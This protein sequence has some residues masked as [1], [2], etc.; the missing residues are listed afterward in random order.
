MLFQN[1]IKFRYFKLIFI[2]IIAAFCINIAY[3]QKT[4][5]KRK[6]LEAKR[7]ALQKQI[8][9]NK[10][11][12]E[13]TR[14]KESNSLSQL[15]VISGQIT[16]RVKIIDN[17]GQESFEL[18]LEIEDQ[19]KSIQT[20][21]N[22]LLK[23][24]QDYAQ[25]IVTTYKK[26]NVNDGLLFIFDSKN[27]NE[28]FNRIR[29]LNQYGQFRQRQSLLILNTQKAINAEIN[30]MIS[31]KQKKVMLMGEKEREK[32][33]L[34]TDKKEEAVLLTKLQQKVN[35]L[36]K[37]IIEQEKIAKKLNKAID[38][39]IAKEIEDARKAEEIK[40][41]AAARKAEKDAISKNK[42]KPAEKDNRTSNSYLSPEAL[43]LSNDF[44]SNKGRL[45]WPTD[46]GTVSG[47]FGEHAH[48]TLKGV[49][50]NNNG[51]DITVQA[52]AQVRAV[53]KG[54]VKATFSIPG[55]DRVVLVNHGE[56]F[57]VYA[58]LSTLNV[59]IGQLIETGQILGNVAT[60]A[61]DGSNRL[62]FEI[63]KQRVLQNPQTWIKKGN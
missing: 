44:E 37:Q 7:K 1:H 17:I 16:T 6:D 8:V 59:K 2:G 52:N 61:E 46:N 29:Y 31:I 10:K 40:M 23:L 32:M 48:P 13:Q 28:A 26:R 42:P 4:N 14:I 19:R 38:D 36:K 51:I 53:F 60:N 11:I 55:M 54:T 9:E 43:K 39:L 56:Y 62:H 12:L 35:D 63:Y 15:K 47:T 41:R 5:P 33:E 20:L 45:P 3:A 21:E 34:E 57:S 24:K 58:R 50:T 22:D 49:F 30:E 18:S 25:S 27:F